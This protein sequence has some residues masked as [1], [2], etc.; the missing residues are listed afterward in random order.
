M[1]ITKFS[2]FLDSFRHMVC[3]EE[4][5]SWLKLLNLFDHAIAPPTFFLFCP[6]TV[7][8][9]ETINEALRSTWQTVTVLY[10]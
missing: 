8:M 6:S 5:F 4:R 10:Q 9:V 3:V 2:C 7:K 1:P